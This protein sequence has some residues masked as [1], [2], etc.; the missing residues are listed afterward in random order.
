MQVSTIKRFHESASQV[1]NLDG[2]GWHPFDRQEVTD[3]CWRGRCA[4]PVATRQANRSH[5]LD[6]SLFRYFI[7]A[8]RSRTGDDRSCAHVATVGGE[9]KVLF[10]HWSPQA[11]QETRYTSDPFPYWSFSTG[12][13]AHYCSVRRFFLRHIRPTIVVKIDQ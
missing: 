12:T 13:S 7:L 11:D 1:S 2:I 9:V 5:W 3:A 6:I 10:S 8:N 4:L